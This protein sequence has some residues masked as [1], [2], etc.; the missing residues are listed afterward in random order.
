MARRHRPRRTGEV[1]GR[2]PCRSGGRRGRPALCPRR[3]PRTGRRS[4]GS[5]PAGWRG[6]DKTGPR[7]ADSFTRRRRPR[8]DLRSRAPLARAVVKRQP[9]GAIQPYPL[10][11]KAGVRNRSCLSML[12]RK[13]YIFVYPDTGEPFVLALQ[14]DRHTQDGT[15]AR[16]EKDVLETS[17]ILRTGRIRMRSAC[18]TMN[19]HGFI[20]TT[21][22]LEPV[23][24]L[25]MSAAIPL[26]VFVE[27][28][29][30]PT[31]RSA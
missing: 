8:D 26:V 31:D 1:H 11:E 2:G 4:L 6:P 30:A 12:V 17:V 15:R 25:E 19:I 9:A 5:G 28:I 14:T 18:L 29:A 7:T 10:Y 20:E 27:M 22:A 13:R 3:G 23:G 16:V 24:A 21:A